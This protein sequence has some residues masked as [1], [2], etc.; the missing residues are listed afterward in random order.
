MEVYVWAS[1]YSTAGVFGG[2]AE[3]T[4]PVNITGFVS[5]SGA[6]AP[7]ITPLTITPTPEPTTL[8]LCG[9]GGALAM[10]FRMRRKA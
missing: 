6:F 5:Q 3:P 2:T 10:I 4:G 9:A 7:E 1:S 8:G